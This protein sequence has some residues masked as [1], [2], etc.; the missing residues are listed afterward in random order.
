MVMRR[1]G[2][3]GGRAQ[4]GPGDRSV[5]RRAQALGWFSI[6]LGVAQLVAPR[7]VSR[8]IGV[9]SHPTLM[10][11]LGAREL[12]AGLGILQDPHPG[13]W[14]WAR[15]AGDAA[16]LALLG[17]AIT[18]LTAARPRVALAAAAVAGVTVIDLLTGRDASRNPGA[19]EQPAMAGGP[20]QVEKSVAVNRSPEECYAFWR[21]LENLPRF[22]QHLES[23]RN[24]DDKRSHWVA[25]AP[26]GRTVEWDAEITEDRPNEAL[27]W[28]SLPGA[29]VDNAGTVRFERGPGG[30]GTMVRV[31]MRYNPPGG[32][33]GALL[34][35]VVME[36]PNVQVQED[37]RRFKR[38]METGDVPTTEG[39]PTGR[40]GVVANLLS[41]VSP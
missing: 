31:R 3:F 2:E 39:Q 14:L 1:Q 9:N 40:R 28:R 25:K 22:M 20:I 24:L 7:Q 38:V 8:L 17:N 5:Q 34:A 37:L 23:V 16:D 15:V 29:D 11:L 6:G 36:E 21:N 12:A 41:K 32:A 26:A 33:L 18:S 10:R 13:K 4:H 30:R 35:K 19:V 27:D